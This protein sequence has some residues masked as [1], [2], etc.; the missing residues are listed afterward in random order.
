M[1][2]NVTQK[3]SDFQEKSKPF[4]VPIPDEKRRLM[5]LKYK[6]FLDGVRKGKK[7]VWS[8][9]TID[10]KE[11]EQMF[12]GELCLGKV[13]GSCEAVPCDE[14]SAEVKE[15]DDRMELY[16]M[17]S[18]LKKVLDE[19]D[20]ETKQF[21]KIHVFSDSVYAINVAREWISLWKDTNF[22]NRPNA[23]LLAELDP[24]LNMCQLEFQ[25]M[26]QDDCE[27]MEKCRNTCLSSL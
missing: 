10:I 1:S 3:E 5:Q 9:C 14:D 23:D 8:G 15:C 25:W 18:G 13:K 17:I 21:V 2:E 22:V 27:Q 24:L 6:L 4:V 19:F 11:K 12:G 16:A 26:P 7:G 20:E